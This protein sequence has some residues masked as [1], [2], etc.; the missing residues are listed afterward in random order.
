MF[1]GERIKAKD[2]YITRVAEPTGCGPYRYLITHKST[3]WRAFETLKEMRLWLRDYRLVPKCTDRRG[4]WATF[5]ASGPD[6]VHNSLMNLEQFIELRS[7]QDR[8]DLSNGSYTLHKLIYERME[9]IEYHLNP[10]VKAR[11]IFETFATRKAL[12]GE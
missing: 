5:R 4:K 2:I 3:S 8:A 7:S 10:N 6:I 1:N 11:P 9:T 12:R